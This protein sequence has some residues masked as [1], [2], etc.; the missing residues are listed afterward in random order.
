MAGGCG[1]KSSGSAASAD[2]ILEAS[3][4]TAINRRRFNGISS[5]H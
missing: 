3:K 5:G 4:E 1:A 2:E